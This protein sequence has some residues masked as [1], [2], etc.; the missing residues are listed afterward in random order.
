MVQ[1]MMLT[2]L[3][4]A[5][6]A[7]TAYWVFAPEPD[8]VAFRQGVALWRAGKGIERT[9]GEDRTIVARWFDGRI[10]RA[11]DVCVWVSPRLVSK[12]LG[13]LHASRRWPMEEVLRRWQTA[14]DELGGTLAFAIRLCVL[15][16]IGWDGDESAHGEPGRLDAVQWLLTSG[17][18]TPERQPRWDVPPWEPREAPRYRAASS[19]E[20]PFQTAP[21]PILPVWK[22]SFREPAAALEV[23]PLCAAPEWMEAPSPPVGMLGRSH[24]G[25]YW[26]RVPVDGLRLHPEGFELRL[27]LNGHERVAAWRF[28]DSQAR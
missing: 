3:A 25:L 8:P 10:R 7:S 27:L 6:A 13:Y 16:K 12:R 18:G 5:L 9:Y 15:P 22:G 23:D 19:P 2:A 20:W 17:P 24:A 11:A 14:R 1:E 28:R 21:Q 26:L 4:G